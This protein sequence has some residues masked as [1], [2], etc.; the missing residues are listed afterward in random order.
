MHSPTQCT[1][2]SKN[3]KNLTLLYTIKMD[4]INAA[5]TALELQNPPNYT[6]TAKEFNVIYF[7]FLWHYWQITCAKEDAMEMKSFLSI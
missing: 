3:I 7:I 2:K 5:F 4:P 1:P 6:W